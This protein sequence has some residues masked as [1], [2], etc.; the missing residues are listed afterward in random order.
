MTRDEAI[1]PKNIKAMKAIQ[2]GVSNFLAAAK[3]LQARPEFVAWLPYVRGMQIEQIE[4]HHGRLERAQAVLE[5]LKHFAQEFR[6][7]N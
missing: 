7:D 1:N 5:R 2:P 3:R 4:V 6:L